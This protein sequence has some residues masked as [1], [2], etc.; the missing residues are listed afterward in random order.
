MTQSETGYKQVRDAARELL[1]GSQP[2][3]TFQVGETRIVMSKVRVLE[4]NEPMPD[5]YPKM[6]LP[7]ADDYSTWLK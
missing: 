6:D 3:R 7:T 1:Q 2:S 5:P 4:S